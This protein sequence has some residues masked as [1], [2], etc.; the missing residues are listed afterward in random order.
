M[1]L[2]IKNFAFL[3]FMLTLSLSVFANNALAS[4]NNASL[5]SVALVG[6]DGYFS[7]Y[8]Y[9]E[10][11][12]HVRISQ[13]DSGFF[14]FYPDKINLAKNLG[15]K[16][17]FSKESIFSSIN[18]RDSSLFVKTKK[19][20][21]TP[22]FVSSIPS[23]VAI[24]FKDNRQVSPT[25][26][27]SE[28]IRD[29][30]SSAS[31]PIGNSSNKQ[32][33]DTQNSNVKNNEETILFVS[34]SKINL[35]KAPSANAEVAAKAM[36]GDKLVAIKKQGS[37]YAVKNQNGATVWVREDVVDKGAQYAE[38]QKAKPVKNPAN[39]EILGGKDSHD[40]ITE[41]EYVVFTNEKPARRPQGNPQ[42]NV[43]AYASV[44][45]QK[46]QAPTDSSTENTSETSEK[47]IYVYHK[48]GRDPFLPLDKS[49]FIREGLPNVTSM[50]LVGIL[51]DKNDAIALF[52]ETK[53]AI[54]TSFSMKVGD[55]I[56]SGKL[57][58]IEPDKVVFLIREA[59][60]S[61]TVEK[62]LNFN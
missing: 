11:K 51:Y 40:V 29:G 3:Q 39:F 2:L 17:N 16:Y 54:T 55:P 48:R 38:T 42:N 18:F 62:E 12:S 5:D 1:K 50:K 59:T 4:E 61:Y 49:D 36:L 14:I 22:L 8:L 27:L 32:Q 53:G 25:S 20:G 46:V 15:K 19:D 52:E 57:L 24:Y 9:G 41:G 34:K 58:R 45:E 13:A 47:K 21:A 44:P 23:G 56:V 43:S 26:I 6:R 31:I 30:V 60:F 35:R 37:W 7:L 10:F 33:T 28:K